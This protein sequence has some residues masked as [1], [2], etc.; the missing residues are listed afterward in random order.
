MIPYAL[1]ADHIRHTVSFDALFHHRKR[2]KMSRFYQIAD[3][4]ASKL[5]QYRFLA[6]DGSFLNQRVT[7]RQLKSDA[8]ANMTINII[9]YNQL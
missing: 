4:I 7:R 1:Y 6:Q 8:V 3:K 9:Y 2:P 5:R